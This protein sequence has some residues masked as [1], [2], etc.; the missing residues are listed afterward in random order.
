MG[1]PVDVTGKSTSDDVTINCSRLDHC[2][3][4]FM[5]CCQNV[6]SSQSKEVDKQMWK[7]SQIEY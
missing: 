2:T 1:H 5:L 7:K 4:F 3:V 6:K